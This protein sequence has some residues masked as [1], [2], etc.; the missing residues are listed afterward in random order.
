MQQV[1]CLRDVDRAPDDRRV[2]IEVISG[3]ALVHVQR[4]GDSQLSDDVIED[5]A[6]AKGLRI[7]EVDGMVL[8]LRTGSQ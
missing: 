6:E 7:G 8:Q 1:D 5:I 3:D 2:Q 4:R